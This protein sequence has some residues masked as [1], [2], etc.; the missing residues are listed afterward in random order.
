[1][2]VLP[3]DYNDDGVVNAADYIVWRNHEGKTFQLPN[4]DPI[5][6]PGEVTEGDYY[7][8]RH[9]YGRT[10]GSGGASSVLPTSVP[11]PATLVLLSVW[12]GALALGRVASRTKKRFL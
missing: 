8:W 2:D 11:E 6:T 5:T 3:G 4:E 9:N 7:V 1:M 10:F 12:I